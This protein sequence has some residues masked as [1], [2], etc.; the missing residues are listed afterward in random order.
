[1]SAAPRI[2]HYSDPEN[3][4]EQVNKALES[5][6]RRIPPTTGLAGTTDIVSLQAQINQLKNLNGSDVNI[7]GTGVSG[8][9]NNP[10]A[11]SVP[12]NTDGT[13][14]SGDSLNTPIALIVPV[15]IGNGGT[16]LVQVAT[17]QITTNGTIITAGTAQAQ[18]T[19]ALSGVT[20]KSAAMWSLPNVPDAT[21]Q[22]GIAMLLVCTANL[23]TPYLVNPTAGSITPVA[24]L[25]NIKVIL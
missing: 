1:M 21:W 12:V 15:T 11:G 24:Q 2:A 18:P 8:P 16:G 6:I 19:L 10:A 17:Q 4:I 9:S 13:T 3:L 23:V 22:T 7:S 25:V 14:I 20:T 5:V